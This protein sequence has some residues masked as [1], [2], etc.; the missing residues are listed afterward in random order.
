M[1]EADG[2]VGI[3]RDVETD[4]KEYMRAYWTDEG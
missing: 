4:K 2:R 3:E 1:R